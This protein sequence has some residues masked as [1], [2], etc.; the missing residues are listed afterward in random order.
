MSVVVGCSLYEGVMLAAVTS[1]PF[2][3]QL[4]EV[5]PLGET[6]QTANPVQ[7]TGFFGGKCD[8]RGGY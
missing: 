1:P 6:V 5:I 7:T 3:T 8:L 2:I 4:D